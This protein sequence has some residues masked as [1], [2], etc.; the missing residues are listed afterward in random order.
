MVSMTLTS[1]PGVPFSP[2]SPSGPGIP[3]SPFAPLGPG[4]PGG[5]TGP[6]NQRS[7]NKII[8]KNNLKRKHPRLEI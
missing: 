4:G 1:G 8:K 6:Y 3:S 5:P 2:G 7:T